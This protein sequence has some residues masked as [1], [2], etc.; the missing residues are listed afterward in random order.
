MFSLFNNRNSDLEQPNTFRFIVVGNLQILKILITIKSKVVGFDSIL[1]SCVEEIITKT[2]PVIKAFKSK[3][4]LLLTI[5]LE[6]K[7]SII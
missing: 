3:S 2:L 5:P 1:I 6:W 4:L 7:Y